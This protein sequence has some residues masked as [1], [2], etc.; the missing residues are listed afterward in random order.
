MFET[1]NLYGSIRDITLNIRDV[2]PSTLGMYY[3]Q[4]SQVLPRT[5]HCVTPNRFCYRYFF[6]GVH[7]LSC[8]KEE[9][10]LFVLR[11]DCSDI[12]SSVRC[13][14]LGPLL[15]PVRVSRANLMLAKGKG[16]INM[17]SLG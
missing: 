8:Y 5:P 1:E 16:R 9:I 10:Y 11:K 7:N 17:S 15:M 6:G 3:P 12:L 14:T 13:T 4:P 2:L